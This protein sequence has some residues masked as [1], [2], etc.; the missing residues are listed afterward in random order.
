MRSRSWGR[1][2]PRCAQS[3]TTAKSPIGPGTTT[4]RAELPDRGRAVRPDGADQQPGARRHRREAW[5]KAAR[6]NDGPG[7]PGTGAPMTSSPRLLIR[8]IR[9]D[10]APRSGSSARSVVVPGPMVISQ[11]VELCAQRGTRLPQERDL[12]CLPSHRASASRAFRSSVPQH[13]ARWVPGDRPYE[14]DLDPAD[15]LR[16]G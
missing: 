9:P 13:V 14:G 7:R 16:T 15:G 5:C 2:V 1:R 11:S 4:L 10:S 6:G 8:S 12:I 3:S